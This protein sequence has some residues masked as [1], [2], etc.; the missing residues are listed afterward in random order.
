ME[1]KGSA[2]KTIVDYVKKN[3]SENF[4][5]WVD[6]L[7]ESSKAIISQPIL[8]SNWYPV[9]EAAIIPTEKIG[10]LFFDNDAIKSAWHSGRFSAECAL[11][12][13]YKFF[14]QAAS[15]HFIIGKASRIL[16]TYYVPSEISVVDKGDK[17]VT[18]HFTKMGRPSSIIEARISG[19]IEKAME[20]SGAKNVNVRIQKS[21]AI[22]DA[23]TEITV[24]WQ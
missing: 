20:I 12:G 5:A 17:Y 22:G 23:Y 18:L 2:V 6:S 3:H 19:W 1:I 16:S 13:I 7:P 24:T 4:Q 15:P 21:L 14:V 10:E 11:T 9:D 8:P